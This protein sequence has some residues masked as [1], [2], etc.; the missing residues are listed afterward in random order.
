VGNVLV[1]GVVIT[2]TLQDLLNTP[3]NQLLG[4]DK[5]IN[6]NNKGEVVTTLRFPIR[7]ILNLGVV[8]GVLGQNIYST[9]IRL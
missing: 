6:I 3:Y 7:N 4:V 8:L 5:G 2:L 9:L 1:T